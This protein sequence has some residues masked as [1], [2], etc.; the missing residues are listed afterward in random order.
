[1]KDVSLGKPGQERPAIESSWTRSRLHGVRK[2]AVPC[3]V[4]GPV[5]TEGSLSRAA[6]R[7]LE[8][9]QQEVEGFSAAFLLADARAF[10]LDMRCTDRSVDDAM[11]NLGLAPGVR[12][13]EEKIGTNGLGTSLQ[14][15]RSVFIR[16]PEHFLNVFDPFSCFGHPIV[17]P[18][19]HRLEGAV[20]LACAW[21]EEHPLLPSL[22]RHLVQDI[23]D[24]LLLDS[25]LAQR[26]LLAAFQAATRTRGRAVVV[27]GPGLV[28]ANPSALDLLEPADHPAVQACADPPGPA[29]E[30]IRQLT[31]VSG[32]SVRLRCVPIEDTDGVLIDIVPDRDARRGRTHTDVT[33]QWPLVVIGEPGSGRTTEARRAAGPGATTVDSTAA[34]RRGEALWGAA[35][36]ALLKTDGPAVIVENIEFLS[37]P[38]T[39]LLAKALPGALRKVVLTSTPG[40][41]L[42]G[43]HA[44]LVAMCAERRELVPLR[45]RRH[46]IPQLAQQMLAQVSGSGR[47]RLASETLRVLAAQSWP[48]N[49]TELRKAVDGLAR[50]RSAGDIL[51]S[52]LPASHRDRSSS[53]SPFRQAEREVIIATIDSVNGNKREAARALGVSRSTL[54]NRMRALHIH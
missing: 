37:E 20:N 27:L 10:V 51:P 40:E 19:T 50:L 17:H 43:V 11:T 42:Q 22:I 45:R 21:G 35:L 48:G 23:E 53:A 44:L 12:V 3:L 46:E 15:G 31:L 32:R 4:R 18:V 29:R 24:R 36:G 52:D 39:M 14:T 34:A 16:G 49:L 25:P 38:L 2:D 7:V 13:E 28:L 30:R 47:V 41:H 8:R 26:R 1:M 33:A 5:D 54:Y 9:A 6:G